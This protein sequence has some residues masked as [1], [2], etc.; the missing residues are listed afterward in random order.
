MGDNSSKFST[1]LN[2]TDLKPY[3]NDQSQNN[4]RMLRKMSSGN[5]F[6]SP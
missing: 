1:A 3:Q 5:D 6:M 2:T 4:P